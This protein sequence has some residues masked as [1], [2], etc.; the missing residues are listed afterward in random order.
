MFEAGGLACVLS[1]IRDN[2]SIIHKDTLH[3]AMSVVSRYVSS[4]VSSTALSKVYWVESKTPTSF[5]RLCTKVEPSDE[6]LPSSVECLSALLRHEDSAVA[7]GG[8]LKCF[9]SLADRFIRKNVDPFPLVSHGL[10]SELLNRLANAGGG[11]K[12]SH[13][14]PGGKL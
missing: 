4:Y 3:S 13:A 7:D 6:S 11:V 12:T 5:I 9:A 14:T 10:T 2:A 8:A 1:F